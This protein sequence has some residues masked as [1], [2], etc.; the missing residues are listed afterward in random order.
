GNP[1][2]Q[3]TQ[4]D[5]KHEAAGLK[6]AEA[7]TKTQRKKDWETLRSQEGAAA[8]LEERGIQLHSVKEE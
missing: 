2:P 8:M 3:Q 6:A 4:Y 5:R 1:T 7:F